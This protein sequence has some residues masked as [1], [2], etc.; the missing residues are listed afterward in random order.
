LGANPHLFFPSLDRPLEEGR[1]F[2]PINLLAGIIKP[3][4]RQRPI[5]PDIEELERIEMDLFNLFKPRDKSQKRLKD[6]I[7][8]NADIIQ[9]TE[10]KSC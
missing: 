10:G 8:Y 1:W 5:F 7:I 9:K 2:Q 6:L 3:G 4:A